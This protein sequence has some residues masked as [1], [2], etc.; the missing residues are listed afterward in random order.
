M[1]QCSVASLS[2]IEKLDN[3]SARKHGAP[4]QNR[5]GFRKRYV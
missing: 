3:K 4:Y 5:D 2:Y 1:E